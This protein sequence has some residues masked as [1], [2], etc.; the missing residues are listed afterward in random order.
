MHASFHA[1]VTPTA[2]MR[3]CMPKQT[4]APRLK[5]TPS[6]KPTENQKRLE[7]Q[8]GNQLEDVERMGGNRGGQT[9]YAVQGKLFQ[10]FNSNLIPGQL[11][12]TGLIL[13]SPGL[14][15][16]VYFTCPSRNQPS[17]FCFVCS[18][19]FFFQLCHPLR[20]CL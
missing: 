18:F 9:A 20:M 2:E 10:Y 5:C 7:E 3:A 15:F 8:E 4:V 13:G 14:G 17:Q 11:W 6:L 1:V 12:P 16:P 19:F